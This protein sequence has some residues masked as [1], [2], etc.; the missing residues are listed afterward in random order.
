MSKFL[1][2]ILS[3]SRQ[4]ETNW[5]ERRVFADNSILEVGWESL[6]VRSN[7]IIRWLQCAE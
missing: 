2:K 1:S 3:N 7:Q 5:D 6:A 4:S